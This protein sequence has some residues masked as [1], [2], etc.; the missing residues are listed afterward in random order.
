[1]SQQTSKEFFACFRRGIADRENGPEFLSRPRTNSSFG[2][3]TNDASSW[4]TSAG[5][6]ASKLLDLSDS[7]RAAL[8]RGKK[9]SLIE[10]EDLTFVLSMMT[11]DELVGAVPSKGQTETQRVGLKVIRRARLDKLLASILIAHDEAGA[12]A[13]SKEKME[14]ARLL[15]EKEIAR[16][17]QECWR[18]QF[19]SE[20][21][22]MDKRR[23]DS[24]E[25][26]LREVLFPSAQLEQRG[27]R[28][29]AAIGLSEAEG[30]TH[31][32]PGQ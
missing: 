3:R 23:Y 30:S 22:A 31:Y 28:L 17:L 6:N 12:H 15:P 1:M 18:S 21:L 27:V 13:T 5:W 2:P 8:N 7:V 32:V 14:A 19:E 25:G 11:A 26:S 29:H 10:M 9:L 4:I 24:L 20:Y 16:S